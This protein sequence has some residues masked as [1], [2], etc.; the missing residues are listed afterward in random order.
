MKKITIFSIL[1]LILLFANL[2]YSFDLRYPEIFTSNELISPQ[3]RIKDSQIHIYENRI[4]LDIPNANYARYADTNSM[5]PILDEGAT[6]IE[7]L[8]SNVNDIQVGDIITYEPEWTNKLVVHR[9]IVTGED[10]Q[11]WY[12]YT[13]GDNTNTIDPGKIR[14]EQVRYILV[15]VIY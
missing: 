12:C 10:E 4:V 1:I 3:D 11:G 14:F 9:V 15:G 8:P 2:V 7:I 13:K 5:D 6:G